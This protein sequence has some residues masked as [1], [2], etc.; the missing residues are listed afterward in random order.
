M[1]R[2]LESSRRENEGESGS[3]NPGCPS[4]RGGGTGG[5]ATLAPSGGG[6]PTRGPHPRDITSQT[7]TLAAPEAAATV[8]VAVVG[9]RP[10][11]LS[12]GVGSE[13]RRPLARVVIGGLVPSTVLTLLVLPAG[14][15]LLTRRL[16]NHEPA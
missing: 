5:Q 13:I 7:R 14:Y 11:V 1:V 15:S 16:T 6:R 4:S 2:W 8:I 9:F 12:H 3:A 10:A